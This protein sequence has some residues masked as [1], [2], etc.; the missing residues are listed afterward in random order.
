[1]D[2]ENLPLSPHLNVFQGSFSAF[3]QGCSSANDDPFPSFR[4]FS[5]RASE[6]E[7]RNEKSHKSGPVFHD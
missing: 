5:F 6:V 3:A 2:A 1:M 4:A 7:R